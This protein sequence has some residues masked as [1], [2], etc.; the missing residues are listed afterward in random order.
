MLRILSILLNRVRKRKKKEAAGTE[1]IRSVSAASLRP[2]VFYQARRPAASM[3]AS[4]L[5]TGSVLQ[6]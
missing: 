1:R 5:S 3:M 2:N 4:M 6:G